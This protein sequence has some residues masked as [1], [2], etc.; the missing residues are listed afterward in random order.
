MSLIPEI[1]I[2]T[3]SGPKLI[4]T[5]SELD[6]GRYNCRTPMIKK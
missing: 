2:I 3:V 1:V 5:P 6:I 4:G